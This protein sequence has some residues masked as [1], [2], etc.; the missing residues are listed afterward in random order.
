[1]QVKRRYDEKLIGSQL[2]NSV[3]NAVKSP[4]VKVKIYLII[5]VG[6][7]TLRPHSWGFFIVCDIVHA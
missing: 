4:A 5:I 6:V 1:M 2:E 3:I 7:Q